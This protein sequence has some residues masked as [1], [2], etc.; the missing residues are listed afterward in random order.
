LIPALTVKKAFAFYGETYGR[1]RTYS[2]RWF[3]EAWSR[4]HLRFRRFFYREGKELEL[5]KWTAL[6]YKQIERIKRGRKMHKSE[7]LKMGRICIYIKT[8]LVSHGYWEAFYERVFGRS[9]VS[10]DRAQEYMRK[11]DPKG[12]NRLR[13]A[14]SRGGPEA[15][16]RRDAA[17][18]AKDE[19]RRCQTQKMELD[20][21]FKTLTSGLYRKRD[22]SLRCG[23]ITNVLRKMFGK[24][25]LEYP[26]SVNVI[27]VESHE[28]VEA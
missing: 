20:R 13:G 4:R 25:G 12:T 28:H 8:K 26:V 2:R 5:A 24:Y 17:R 18:K 22:W 6:A 21:T 1:S 11:V 9:G 3:T 19:L 15:K 23:E 14:V 7:C 16:Q 27:E 10:L